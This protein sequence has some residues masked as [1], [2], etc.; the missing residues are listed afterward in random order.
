MRPSTKPTS[1][2]S[3]MAIRAA[4]SAGTCAPV[5]AHRVL[6]WASNP[7]RMAIPSKEAGHALFEHDHF[8]FHAGLRR[9]AFQQ[10]EGLFD[11]FVR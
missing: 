3:P 8:V 5:L 6:M 2:T 4:R 10:L 1:M 11:G 7:R 9:F